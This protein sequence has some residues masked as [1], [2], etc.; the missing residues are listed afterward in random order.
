MNTNDHTA[1]APSGA[2]QSGGGTK[3]K[4]GHVGSGVAVDLT[5]MAVPIAEL[6]VREQSYIPTGEVFSHTSQ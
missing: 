2:A 6:G 4:H 3:S 5:A 1:I